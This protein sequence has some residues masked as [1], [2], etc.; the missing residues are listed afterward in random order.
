M[1]YVI[2]PHAG[3]R[4]RERS[5]SEDLIANALAD[6]TKVG[7]DA[8][9]RLLIKKLYCRNGK[10]RLLLIVGEIAANTLEIITI[11]DTSKV[12]KYL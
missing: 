5:I 11:I 12:K 3:K 10:E 2:K 4:A 7:Y 6:P 1:K 9:G 8:R